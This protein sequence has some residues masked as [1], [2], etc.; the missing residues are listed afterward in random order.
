MELKGQGNSITTGW[1]PS[2]PPE[3]YIPEEIRSEDE[4]T[5]SQNSAIAVLLLTFSQKLWTKRKKG[6]KFWSVKIA[7]FCHLFHH[8]S[9][10]PFLNLDVLF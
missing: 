6:K 2:L 1:K 10:E 5:A 4:S 7:T 9:W 8:L 3:S